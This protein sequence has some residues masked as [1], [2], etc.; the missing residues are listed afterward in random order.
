M[1]Y[2]TFLYHQIDIFWQ[3]ICSHPSLHLFYHLFRVLVHCFDEG[4]HVLRVHVGVK[5]V[6]KVGDV[7]LC[8]KTLQHPLHDFRDLLLEKEGVIQRGINR[9]DTRRYLTT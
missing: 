5:A 7:A 9:P 1:H 3:R 2:Y 6:A 8:A 4:A